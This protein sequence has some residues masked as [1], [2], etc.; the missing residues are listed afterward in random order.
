MTA[1]FHDTKDTSSCRVGDWLQPCPW[2]HPCKEWFSDTIVEIRPKFKEWKLCPRNFC[3]SLID[4]LPNSARTHHF[5]PQF[6]RILIRSCFHLYSRHL[7]CVVSY[8]SR[9]RIH[10]YLVLPMQAE[11]LS[12]WWI[13]T[14]SRVTLPGSSMVGSRVKVSVHTYLHTYQSDESP[15]CWSVHSCDSAVHGSVLIG[16]L[17]PGTVLPHERLIVFVAFLWFSMIFSGC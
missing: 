4:F 5:Q 11:F 8:R 12:R 14:S 7:K 16:S 6:I 17:H 13:S 1:V 10:C 2:L 9:K 15:S 3:T